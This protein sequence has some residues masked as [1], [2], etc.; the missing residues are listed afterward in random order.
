MTSRGLRVRA[1]IPVLATLALLG[2][3]GA[4]A[5][6]DAPQGATQLPEAPNPCAAN[7]CGATS[8]DPTANPCAGD[9]PTAAAPANPCADAPAAAPTDAP[10]SEDAPQ[11]DH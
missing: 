5:Q 3:G 7:P 8:I 11:G 9:A 6:V 2:C 4:P 1:I 10:A